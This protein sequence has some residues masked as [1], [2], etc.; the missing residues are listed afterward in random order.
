M[1]SASNR[2]CIGRKLALGLLLL[3]LPAYV[4]SQDA[5][6][7]SEQGLELMRQGRYRDAETALAQAL[8]LAGPENPEAL[9]NLASIYHR[10]GRYQEAERLHGLA[11]RAVERLHGPSDIQ[12]AQ[13]LNDLG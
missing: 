2:L 9:Y 11:L 8:K 1:A 10:E 6:S 5:V 7:L 12:V 3:F 13:S 4:F